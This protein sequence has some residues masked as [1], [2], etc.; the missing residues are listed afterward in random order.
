M[1]K[2]L[3]IY[4]QIARRIFEEF[5]KSARDLS[6]DEEKL[7][8]QERILSYF[9]F[10]WFRQRSGYGLITNEFENAH[11]NGWLPAYRNLEVPEKVF[12]IQLKLINEAFAMVKRNHLI[13][14]GDNFTIYLSEVEAECEY[15][16]DPKTYKYLQ[17]QIAEKDYKKV[18]YLYYCMSFYNADLL[19][20]NNYWKIVIHLVQI[21]KL[22]IS[23]NIPSKVCEEI[24]RTISAED[25]AALQKHFHQ[26]GN[27]TLWE[28]THNLWQ[29]F[30][31][32]QDIILPYEIWKKEKEAQPSLLAKSLFYSLCIRLDGRGI[33][34]KQ[35]LMSLIYYWYY[36]F[37]EGH[38]TETIFDG[39]HGA[40]GNEEQKLIIRLF[41]LENDKDVLKYFSVQ[42]DIYCSEREIPEKDRI[43]FLKPTQLQNKNADKV[44]M[45]EKAQSAISYQLKLPEGFDKEHIKYLVGLVYSDLKLIGLECKPYLT[46]FLG[47][48]GIAPSAEKLIQWKGNRGTL[49]YF[50]SNLY[51]EGAHIWNAVANSFQVIRNNKF[52]SFRS[53]ESFSNYSKKKAQEDA[54]QDMVAKIDKCIQEAKNATIK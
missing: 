28:N 31:P 22:M 18:S 19:R 8:E 6:I 37:V 32:Y 20:K 42:Y 38:Y 12:P 51:Q 53:S 23:K 46:Y 9:L 44:K 52:I 41:S 11:N 40:Y 21:I 26:A 4:N 10:N 54:G 30:F 48:E 2:Q 43:S 50:F 1:I 5:Y 39:L 47:G 34:Q 49:K 24:T 17:A 13:H 33:S 7:S 29:E 36:G 16:H 3:V 45:Q 14:T 27:S 25:K 15:E 35:K